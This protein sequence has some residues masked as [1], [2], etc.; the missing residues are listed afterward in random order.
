MSNKPH[1]TMQ[2]VFEATGKN[3][4]EIARDINTS[5]QNINN[6]IKRG[7]SKIGAIVLSNK[8]DLPIDWILTGDD[9]LSNQQQLHDENDDQETPMKTL[10]KLLNSNESFLIEKFRS[11][12]SKN[13]HALIDIIGEIDG[14]STNNKTINNSVINS[15]HSKNEFNSNS[16]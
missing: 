6:W 13:Q 5:P 8:Y 7:V 1:P 14:T 11:L 15:P 2:R 16:N 3:P 9:D 4:T 10:K 12:S